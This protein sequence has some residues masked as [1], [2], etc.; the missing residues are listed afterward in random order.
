MVNANFIYKHA[1]LAQIKR[2]HLFCLDF[3]WD[4]V[5]LIINLQCQVL[6]DVKPLQ[7]KPVS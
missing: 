3:N 7:P 6:I 2:E 4:H 5:C 1:P